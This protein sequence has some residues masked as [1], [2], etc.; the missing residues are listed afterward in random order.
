MHTKLFISQ[1]MC[2]KTRK[3][4]LAVRQQAK[5][6]VE[7]LLGYK[8]DLVEN[9]I[10]DIPDGATP[11]WCLTQSLLSLADA[12][13][14]YFCK[15]WE[16]YRGCRIEREIAS[17][18]HLHIIDEPDGKDEISE[19]Y[20]TIEKFISYAEAQYGKSED[21]TFAKQKLEVSQL[22]LNRVISEGEERII[23]YEKSN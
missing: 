14:V 13:I 7:N 1:P 12:D 11:L 4:I 3:E 6:Q 20:A 9:F 8:V 21:L 2:D 10:E 16:E 5:L 15:G 17:E 19:A 23:K 18:Y 22:W